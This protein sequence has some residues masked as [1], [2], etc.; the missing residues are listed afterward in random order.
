MANSV[1]KSCATRFQFRR[2][3][4]DL[5][6][7]RR[8]P[9]SCTSSSQADEMLGSDVRAEQRG[10][11]LNVPGVMPACSHLTC[12][13]RQRPTTTYARTTMIR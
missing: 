5:E 12:S 6:A 4:V 8:Y 10:A 9:T 3:Y 1:S 7:G 13:R 2:S 11:H